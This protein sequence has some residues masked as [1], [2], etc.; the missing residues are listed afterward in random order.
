MGEES[1]PPII[2]V[3]GGF[4][5]YFLTT[6]LI[7]LILKKSGRL[8]YVK[9]VIMKRSKALSLLLMGSLTVGGAVG[10]GKSEKDQF[11]AYSTVTECIQG[12]QFT[13]QECQEFANEALAQAKAATFAGREECETKFGEGACEAAPASGGDESGSRPSSSWAPMFW[14]FMAGRF[15]SGGNAMQGATPLYKGNAGGAAGTPGLRTAWG[16][17]VTPGPK[18]QIPPTPGM[19]QNMNHVAKPRLERQSSG[20]KASSSGFNNSGSTRSSS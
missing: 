18:G 9:D 7:F 19:K 14:G 2:C 17:S 13:D 1:F 16:E 15:L 8:L 4:D 20:R 12:G 3:F 6:T 11:L 5:V 10:C